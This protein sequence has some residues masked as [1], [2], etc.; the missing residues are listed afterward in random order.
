MSDQ[1]NTEQTDSVNL[2]DTQLDANL[3]DTQ[4]D[5]EDVELD[6][7]SVEVSNSNGD[8]EENKEDIS[9]EKLNEMIMKKLNALNPN[10]KDNIINLFSQ[11]S[12]GGGLGGGNLSNKEKLRMALSKKKAMRKNSTAKKYLVE[13]NKNKL[14]EDN[15][16]KEEELKLQKKKE[17]N[18]RK[19]ERKKRARERRKEAL[20]DNQKGDTNSSE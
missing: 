19:R 10:E 9:P 3:D 20:V 4:L 13:K 12:K 1:T 11:M 5:D 15:F 8:K 2:D 18:R 7:D 14:E 16:N 6:D 17:A